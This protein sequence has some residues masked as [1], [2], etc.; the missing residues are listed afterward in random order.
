M[1]I[2]DIFV[3]KLYAFHFEDEED[4]EYDRNIELWTN[5]DYLIQFA[6]ANAK[7]VNLEKYVSDRLEDAEQIVDLI[8]YLSENET[9]SLSSFFQPISP[10]EIGIVRLSLQK[11]KTRQRNRRNDLRFYA[12]KIDEDCFVITGG[13]IKVSQ[14]MQEH[15]L[16]NIELNKLNRC[17]QYL[18]ENGVF[19]NESFFEL[20]NC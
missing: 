11:G 20:I 14:T 16:T 8:E 5:P 1:K 3:P 18:N 4:N 2:V 9:D 15:E 12:I 17:K 7:D 13:A 10:S 19:D 6:K